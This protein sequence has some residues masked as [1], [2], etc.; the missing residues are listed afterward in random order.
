MDQ[1]A[2]PGKA[3]SSWTPE[4]ESSSAVQSLVTMVRVYGY[5]SFSCSSQAK[6]QLKLTMVRICMEK[7]L[8]S[9][10]PWQYSWSSWSASSSLSGFSPSISVGVLNDAW[11]ATTTPST[12]AATGFPWAVHRLVDSTRRSSR[13]FRRSDTQR[14]RRSRLAKKPLSVLFA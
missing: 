11:A 14:W 9:T 7:A 3:W 13:H 1:R 10:Q 2:K 4:V 8:D 6:F 12:S 5:F